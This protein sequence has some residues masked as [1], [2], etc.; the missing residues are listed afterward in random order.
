MYDHTQHGVTAMTYVAR[1]AS[2]VGALGLTPTLLHAQST[3]TVRNGGASALWIFANVCYAGMRAQAN[4]SV[5]W[6][7]VTFLMGFPGTLLSVL[8]VSEGSER[9]YGIDLPKKR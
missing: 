7:L 2:L 1:L 5:F 6:R 9:A 8:V 3:E 4:P